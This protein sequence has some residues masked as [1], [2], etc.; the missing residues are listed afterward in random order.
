MKNV[1][2]IVFRNLTDADFFNINKP[3]GVEDRGGG[4]SYIDFPVASIGIDNWNNFFENVEGIQLEEKTQ[5]PSW[6]FPV[7]SLGLRA[8]R[9]VQNLTIY[10]RRSASI[11]IAS[12]KIHSRRSNR[13]LA[14]L[15]ENGFPEPIDNL[16]RE[17]CPQG[18]IIFL[19]S[20]YE[21]EV[22]AGWFLNDGT[23][24]S[25]CPSVQSRIL[26]EGMFQNIDARDGDSGCLEF[27][28]NQ[29]FLETT[30]GILITNQDDVEENVTVVNTDIIEVELEPEES[31]ESD[32]LF[33]DDLAHMGTSTPAIRQQIVNL[34][35]RN[36]KIVNKLK[37]LYA[38]KCQITGEEFIFKKKNGQ[39]Y[40]E[41]H[42]LI[43]LG[44]NGD[45]SVRNLVILCPQMHRMLHY[46][47]V[48]PV[49]LTKMVI[50]PDGSA[51]LDIEI[52]SKS[53]T[54][55]W[56]SQHARLFDALE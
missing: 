44:E 56:H 9:N 42:H 7:Y 11:S 16:N 31:P 23:S 4:Q 55:R 26:L 37:E 39:G 43:P 12:Q 33:G 41:A 54:I 51:Y 22:W 49:D 19:I 38:N 45:D 14:W 1:K 30:Q 50:E 18:L 15:P 47:D 32:I 35:Q 28:E 5:G 8:P 29:L 21:G 53:Y 10:Q 13:V 27:E 46:A 17:Q 34:R 20:T 40:T 36:K 52:N 48:S 3:Q 6:T 24:P 2:S 25:P